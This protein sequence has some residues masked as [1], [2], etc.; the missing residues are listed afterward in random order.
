MVTYLIAEDTVDEHIEALIQSKRRVVN[1]ATEGALEDTEEFNQAQ[2]VLD[3]LMKG[4]DQS[5]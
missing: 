4:L 3:M 2:L 1:N 5:A